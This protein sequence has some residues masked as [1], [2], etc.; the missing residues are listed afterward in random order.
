MFFQQPAWEAL[1]RIENHTMPELIEFCRKE[2]KVEREWWYLDYKHIPE[3]FPS[4]EELFP[5]RPPL[6]KVHKIFQLS[7]SNCFISDP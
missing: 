5:V 2:E 7:Y 1:C 3:F 4:Y 6:K